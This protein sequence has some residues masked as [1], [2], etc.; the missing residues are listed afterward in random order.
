MVEPRFGPR[1]TGLGPHSLPLSP[2]K[3]RALQ[4]FAGV[5][6]QDSTLALQGARLQ[7]L[8]GELSSHKAQP[9]QP[10]KDNESHVTNCKASPYTGCSMLRASLG[11]SDFAYQS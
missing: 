6:C 2:T 9:V 11:V 10:K 7:S 5:Q 8:V 4:G 1:R 3:E